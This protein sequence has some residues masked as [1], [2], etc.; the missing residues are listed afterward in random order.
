MEAQIPDYAMFSSVV[1]LSLHA[2]GDVID[3]AS[4]GPK[5][6]VPRKPVELPKCNA[7]VVMDVDGERFV[8]PVRLPTG[9]V[10]F[11][12]EITTALTGDMR[13]TALSKHQ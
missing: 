12:R 3:L 11:E 5:A 6:V 10:P 4:I 1:R 7:E 2:N 8:W 13:R 9:A